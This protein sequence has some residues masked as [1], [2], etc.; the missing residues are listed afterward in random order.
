MNKTRGML[1]WG[2]LGLLLALYLFSIILA[3]AFGRLISVLL[4][5]M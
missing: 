2:W 4:V 5:G 3:L 1:F